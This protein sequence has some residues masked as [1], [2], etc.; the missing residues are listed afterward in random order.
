[1]IGSAILLALAGI[2]LSFLP[3]EISTYLSGSSHPVFSLALQLLGALYL[4][5]AMLNWMNKNKLLGGIYGRPIT[6][7]NFIHFLV[8]GL[9]LVK[10]TSVANQPAFIITT[11][12][13]STFAVGFGYL[14]LN[15][16]KSVK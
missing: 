2:S 3:Q 14:W 1:M 6:M 7:A 8:G 4:G 16:P 15:T 5:M 9:S 10:A 12:I 11:I 13:Y